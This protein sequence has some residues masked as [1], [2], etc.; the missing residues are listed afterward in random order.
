MDSLPGDFRAL[1]RSI[2]RALIY[3]V[4]RECESCPSCGSPRIYVLDLLPLRHPVN[5]CRTGFVSGCDGCGLVFSNP[6]PTPEALRHFYSPPGEWGSRRVGGAGDTGQ[7]GDATRG[8][9]WSRVFD[10]IHEFV[11][12][13]R[14]GAKVL[15][16][17]CGNGKLLDAL[18]ECGWDTWGVETAV[19][20][21]FPRHHRLDAVPDTSVFDLIVAN[22]VL[23][24]VTDPLGLLRQFARA[25]RIGGYLLVGVPRFDTLPIHRDYKYV[26]NGRA[27]VTAY[28]WPCLQGLLARAGWQPVAPPPD[29]ISKGGG[30]HTYA[31]LRVIAR[32]VEEHVEPAPSPAEAARHALR[33]YYADVEGRPLLERLGW[34][35]LAARCAEARRRHAI[36]IR[37]SRLRAKGC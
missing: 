6:P 26:I 22:H 2:S 30:R 9:S 4:P 36:R 10:P 17:G 27:H 29:R 31:R 19:D 15:D 34:Y 37:K 18:Q 1:M 28:T 12:T 14:P 20:D 21:A 25:G 8:R 23:E 13:P 24:H 35:R 5:G 3:G 11:T 16:F 7:S 33:R 32:R